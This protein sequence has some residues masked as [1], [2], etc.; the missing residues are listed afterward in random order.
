MHN[1][2][3]KETKNNRG[4]KMSCAP[5]RWLTTILN[6]W[7]LKIRRSQI[8][9]PFELATKS[10]IK[11]Y[12]QKTPNRTTNQIRAT[13]NI[14]PSASSSQASYLH[15]EPSSHHNHDFSRILAGEGKREL[16]RRRR[17]S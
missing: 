11:P 17:K 9:P 10:Q 1:P 15:H 5:Q 3:T 12:N 13:I 8:K 14:S 2:T 4:K 6:T 16:D 7:N